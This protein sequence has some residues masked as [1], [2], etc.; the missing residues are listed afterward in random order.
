MNNK[1]CYKIIA[2][3]SIIVSLHGIPVR[4]DACTR[5]VY[6]GPDDMIVTGRTMDWKEVQQIANKHELSLSPPLMNCR[7]LEIE[8]KCIETTATDRI[9]KNKN[10][11]CT[12]YRKSL[13]HKG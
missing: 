8:G 6:L 13:K 7:M 9:C 10:C 2:V 5:A 11:V 3:V 12:L 4:T 1:V